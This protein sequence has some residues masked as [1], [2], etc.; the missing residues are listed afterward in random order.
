MSAAT[1]P[2]PAPSAGT[3]PWL[4]Q[5]ISLIEPNLPHW[6]A[7]VWAPRTREAIGVKDTDAA[8]DRFIRAIL[9]DPHNGTVKYA[10]DACEQAG[11]DEWA[12]ALRDPSLS[13]YGWD[14]F[15]QITGRLLDAADIN[16][17]TIGG[18]HARQRAQ[19]AASVTNYLDAAV[20]IVNRQGIGSTPLVVDCAVKA[21]NVVEESRR[22]WLWMALELDRILGGA[23]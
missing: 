4:D 20:R 2:T 16:Q 12:Q 7:E 18:W 9:M 13:V 19:S 3:P 23:A 21:A 5:V 15:E 22:H 11:M 10:A 6:I 14:D 17:H 8:A 1:E